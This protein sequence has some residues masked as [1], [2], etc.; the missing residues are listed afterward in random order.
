MLVF[1]FEKVKIEKDAFPP[2]KKVSSRMR[3]KL[4][5]QLERCGKYELY[6]QLI[7]KMFPNSLQSGC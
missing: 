5:K 4:L 3:E 7:G 2:H 1:A 6:F